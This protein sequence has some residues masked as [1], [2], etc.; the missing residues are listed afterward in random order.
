[1]IRQKTYFLIRFFSFDNVLID[2]EISFSHISKV[3]IYWKDTRKE[4][5]C[6][7]I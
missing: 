7:K 1:M 2:R 4:Q 3:M 5:F 6:W